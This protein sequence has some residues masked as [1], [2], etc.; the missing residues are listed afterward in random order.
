MDLDNIN[1]IEVLRNVAKEARTKM[2][3]D[4][5]SDYGVYTFKKVIGIIV[6]KMNIMSLFI[7][8][9]VSIQECSLIKKLINIWYL[10]VKY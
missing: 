9:I 10:V 6:S 5:D 8:M 4:A 2:K 3:E 7:L 1:D